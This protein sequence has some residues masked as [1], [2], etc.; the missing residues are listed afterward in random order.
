MEA[1]ENVSGRTVLGIQSVKKLSPMLSHLAISPN[2]FNGVRESRL[3]LG[4]PCAANICRCVPTTREPP[5]LLPARKSRGA[6][7]NLLH[8]GCWDLLI[9]VVAADTSRI[10]KLRLEHLVR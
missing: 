2:R 1:S 9:V 6:K 5:L 10:R 4:V 7:R 3:K 8:D